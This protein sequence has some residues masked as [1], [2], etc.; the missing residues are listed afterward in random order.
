ME[1]KIQLGGELQQ[2]QILSQRQRQ[3]LEVLQMPR[4]ELDIYLNEVLA[5]NPLLE[6]NESPPEMLME[7]PPAKEQSDM[8]KED[9]SELDEHLAESDSWHNDLPLPPEE[10]EKNDEIDFFSNIA[11]PPPDLEDMLHAEISGSGAPEN[12]CRLA[13]VIVDSLD[14]SGFLDTPLA[15][16]AMSC[17]ASLEEAEQA[18]EL[19]QSF[20]PAG[21]GAR[22]LAESLTIQLKRKNQLSQVL[23]K[24]LAL[25]LEKIGTTPIATLARQLKETPE[26]IRSALDTL[27]QLNPAPA[28]EYVPHADYIQPEI[29]F[30]ID[31]KGVCRC[32]MLREREKRIILSPHYHEWLENRDLSA[33]DREFIQEKYRAAKEFL[34]ALASRKETLLRLG[35]FLCV[36][37]ADFFHNGILALHPLTMKQ[38]GEALS[39]HETTISRAVSGKY[40]K[41]PFGVMPMKFFFSSGYAGSS[42]GLS[43]RS[44]EERI[45]EM[46]HSEDPDEPLSDDKIAEMLK[47]EGLNI[48]RRTVA[49]Y[50]MKLNIPAYS[51]RKK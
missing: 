24:M 1:N 34:Q 37:Q 15:D 14:E 41:T 18:L 23:E 36:K 8:E 47:A 38:A 25:G 44:V 33:E 7:L 49:K 2:K 13:E 51:M 43:A 3:A 20:D 42:E 17:D 12:I 19:V 6:E 35:E 26:N 50:R 27:R 30:F 9:E 22:N 10:S 28:G 31:A 11:A 21:I 32:R 16:V 40:A 5:A 48:A 4:Q 39:L 29:E 45:K 46:I